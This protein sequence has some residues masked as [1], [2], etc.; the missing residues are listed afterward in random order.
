MF[1]IQKRYIVTLLNN[2]VAQNDISVSA[3]NRTLSSIKSINRRYKM[4]IL[5]WMTAATC[6]MVSCTGGKQNVPF[7]H[8]VYITQPAATGE[9]QLKTYS[10]IVEEA[11]EISLG[12]KTAGQLKNILVKEGDFVEK[13]QL[14][15]ELDDADYR[16][17]VEA[18]QIQYDQLKEEVKRTTQLF[19]QQSISANDY[20]KATA[21]LRQLEVQL[22]VNKNKLEYTKLYA[23]NSGYIR[24][25]NF[26]PAEMV[27]AGTAVFRLLD[28]SRLEV[29]ADV[30][31]KAYMDR[32]QFTRFSCKT[33]YTEGKELPMTLISFTPKADN[34][35]LYRMRFAFAEQPDKRVTAGMNVEVRIRVNTDSTGYALPLSTIFRDGDGVCVWILEPDSTVSKRRI[36]IGGTT[37]K[38]EAVV[39]SGLTGNEKVVRAGVNMLREGEKVRVID[40]PSKT[41]EGGLL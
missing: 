14:L 38:G 41:N 11:H 16:L 20:E 26:S 29:V 18:L 35:Q 32:E 23:P 6:L 7:V 28:V 9:E 24:S 4:K 34:N 33:A 30:P 12:F 1:F 27:D 13:G 15:A 39:A 17:G 25:V 21:G 22:Q 10:G 40:A 2:S 8:S 5:Q 36:E 37:T 19:E 31:V 3:K